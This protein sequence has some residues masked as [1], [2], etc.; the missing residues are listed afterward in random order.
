MNEIEKKIKYAIGKLGA[1]LL[2]IVISPLLL[3][4]SI[5]IRI[6]SPGS[7]IFRQK[8][9]GYNGKEFEIYKFRTMV[10]DAENMGDGL[11]IRNEGD[12][13]ITRIGRILRKTSLDELPQFFNIL[14]GD[15]CF[16]GPR[17]P[18]TYHPYDGYQNY[19]EK[20]KKRFEM[21]PGITGLAQVKLRNSGTWDE[22][23]QID[24][25]YVEKYSLWLDIK[26]I[27]M[28]AF[29]MLNKEEYT[30]EKNNRNINR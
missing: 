30:A 21:K 20:A 6:T 22:R 4:I 17:P 1:L 24:I 3:I 8:R 28:T 18:V 5:C 14:K 15:M 23:I 12:E 7:I 26:I 25:Q 13:R 29:S 27:F 9:L 10:A 2:V 11:V 19:P 16:V